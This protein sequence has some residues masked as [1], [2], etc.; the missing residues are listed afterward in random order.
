M[1]SARL[2]NQMDIHSGGIDLAF[3]HHDNEL[4][5]SSPGLDDFQRAKS[6]APRFS[7]VLL[8][9]E[10]SPSAANLLTEYGDEIAA[11]VDRIVKNNFGYATKDG[12]VY[13][14]INVS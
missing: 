2:G 13:F 3:P 1:A 4:A 8:A 5:Q 11:F 10:P 9:N 7:V 6:E 14:D 12:S